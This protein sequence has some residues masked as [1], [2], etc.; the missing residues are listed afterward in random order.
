[1]AGVTINT[2]DLQTSARKYRK[3]LLLIPMQAL[4]S[5]LQYM[6]LRPG[7]RYSETVGELAGDMQFGP[8]SST[9]EDD[10]DVVINPRTLYT[11]FGSVVKNFEP[12]KVYASIYGS[13]ITKG[14]ALKQTDITK[15]VLAFLCA[16]LGNNLNRVLFSAVRNAS[17]T[18]S[19]DL[20][21]GFDTIAKKEYDDGKISAD[22]GNM[23]VIEK[24]T[25][26]NAVDVLKQ[27][28]RDADEELTSKKCTLFVPRHVFDD[29]CDDYKATSGAVPY[30]KQF[31]QYYVEGFSNI[32]IVPLSN[33]AGSP[34]I[35][36]TTRSNML[37]GVNQMGEEENIEVARFKAFVL[38]FIA[39]MFFGCQYESISKEFMHFATID[40]VAAV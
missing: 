4:K 18:K 8:Y 12:N 2:T 27:I 39:T 34:F 19:K 33:K 30:N 15:Y 5:S 35:Q 36:L 10:E 20:F 24:I 11:Y 17:G 28:C 40:G 29:Y 6:T 3:D 23:T 1:M 26:V 31:N 7:I 25:N 13:A 37:V 21:D 16:K 14:E 32:S 38:Q 22:L 9:R